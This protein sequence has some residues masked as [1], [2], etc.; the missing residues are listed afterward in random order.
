MRRL[1]LIITT[2]Y[3]ALETG[4]QQNCGMWRAEDGWRSIQISRGFRFIQAI[5]LTAVS[6][7]KAAYIIRGTQAGIPRCSQ[8]QPFSRMHCQKEHRVYFQDDIPVPY[9]TAAGGR[10]VK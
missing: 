4:K 3:A 1:A 8:P 10:K 5:I 6:P 7:V 2:F 9:G